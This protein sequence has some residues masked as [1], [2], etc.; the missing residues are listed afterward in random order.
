MMNLSDVNMEM[1]FEQLGLDSSEAAIEQFIT[2]H[3]LPANVQVS[4]AP[5]WSNAQRS[6]IKEVYISNAAWVTFA[7]ELN[8][9]LH[10]DA[11]IS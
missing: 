2:T 8:A 9:R 10:E 4:E 3:Q 1:F 6:F 5:F 7:D 11:H